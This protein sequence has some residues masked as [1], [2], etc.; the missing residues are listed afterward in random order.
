M[1]AGYSNGETVVGIAMAVVGPKG[2]STEALPN[3]AIVVRRGTNTSE[4]FAKG[5]GVT[6]DASGNLQA[7]RR[8][9]EQRSRKISGGTF[10][11]IP[12]NKVGVTTV[13]DVRAA[14]GNVTPS[15]TKANPNHCTMCGVTPQNASQLMRVIPNPAKKPEQQP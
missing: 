5:S 3:E 1:Q 10:T 4:A 15:P 8:F 2:E 12:H 13:G 9:S 6:I 7:F 11:G 14:G